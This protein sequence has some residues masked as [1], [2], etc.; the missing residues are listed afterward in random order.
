[1]FKLKKVIL[2]RC[3]AL[4]CFWMTRKE[5]KD[6]VW[7]QTKE[8]GVWGGLAKINI[9]KDFI[10]LYNKKKNPQ[11][12]FPMWDVVGRLLLELQNVNEQLHKW[13]VLLFPLVHHMVNHPLNSYSVIQWLA[14][15]WFLK[16]TFSVAHVHFFFFSGTGFSF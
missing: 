4:L 11:G 9:N 3:H 16:N 8:F 7:W 13:S 12:S 14:G 1:M 5:I 6:L 10:P 2:K 15:E